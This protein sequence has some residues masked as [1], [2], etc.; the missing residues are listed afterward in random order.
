MWEHQGQL[1]DLLELES[2]G[3]VASLRAAEVQPQD[4]KLAWSLDLDHGE[5]EISDLVEDVGL[6]KVVLED[7]LFVYWQVDILV[8]E[9]VL[10]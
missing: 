3:R 7:A 4:A 6:G 5:A 9:V 8:E 1:L 2:S 10:L